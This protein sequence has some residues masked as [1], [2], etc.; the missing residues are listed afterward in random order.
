[1][2]T[3]LGQLTVYVDNTTPGFSAGD[4]VYA[5]DTTE[6]NDPPAGATDLE[7]SEVFTYSFT[8]V[9]SYGNDL[10][11]TIV[12]DAPVAN[13]LSQD[14]PESEEYVFNIVLSPA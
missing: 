13:D 11:I 3:P 5:L 2:D 6:S 9:I 8:N 12:D 7:T 10:T 14:I 1:V 4:Y